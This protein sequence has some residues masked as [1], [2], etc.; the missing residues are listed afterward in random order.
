MRLDFVGAVIYWRGPSPFYFVEVPAEASSDIK[1]VSAGLTYGWGCIPASVRIND[2]E[3]TTALIPKDGRY[4]VPIR[5]AYRLALE[6]DA[7]MSVAV[8]LSL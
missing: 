3:W 7:G 4:L 6:L 5:K 2:E 8:E 1:A